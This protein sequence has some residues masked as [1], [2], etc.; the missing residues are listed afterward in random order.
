MTTNKQI[1]CHYLKVEGDQMPAAPYPGIIG[2]VIHSMICKT[3]W[4]TWLAHQTQLINENRLNPLDKK[5]R[6]I[7]EDAMI[8]FFDIKEKISTYSSK[9]V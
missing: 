4:S 2:K 8:N 1:Y 9:S 6:L 5:D 7:L 3:A